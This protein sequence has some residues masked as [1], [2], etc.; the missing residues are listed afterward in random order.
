MR[1][2]IFAKIS[3]KALGGVNLYVKFDSEVSLFSCIFLF[4]AIFIGKLALEVFGAL[5]L[6]KRAKNTQN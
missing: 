1:N 5:T 3:K 4:E 6:Q 2:L